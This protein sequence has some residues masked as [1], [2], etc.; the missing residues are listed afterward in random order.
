M[1]QT[2]KEE[3]SRDCKKRRRVS[4]AARVAAEL[5]KLVC[6]FYKLALR[7]SQRT[8]VK[9]ENNR[10][11]FPDSEQINMD[12]KACSLTFIGNVR[13]IVCILSSNSRHHFRIEIS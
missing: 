12:A 1:S 11:N 7:H 9:F 6:Q 5:S 10:I 8:R 2:S 13:A 4:E 3:A